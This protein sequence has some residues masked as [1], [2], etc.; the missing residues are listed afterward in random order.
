MPTVALGGKPV[1]TVEEERE[2]DAQRKRAKRENVREVII[3]RC[4]DRRR[5]DYLEKDDINWLR[6]Y[7]GPNSNC[8]DPFWYPF[9]A[10]QLEMIH[11]IRQAIEYGGDQSLAASRGEGKTTIFER[12]LTKYTLQ[13][14]VKFSV[15]CAATGGLAAQS[16][17]SIKDAI[18]NNTN[19]SADYPEVCIPVHALEN[20]PNRAHYQL[21]T[22]VRHDNNKAFTKHPSKF[23]W[24]GQE[25]IL[26]DVPGAPG[27]AGIIAT[28]GLDAAVRGLKRKGMRPQLVG[29]D[30]PDTEDSAR[31]EDQA[32]KL[33]SRIDRS[34]GGLGGQQR[35]VARVMLTTL[36]S[37][38]AV[39]YKFTDP[40]QKPTWKAKRF[41]FLIKPPDRL[42]LWD[43][44]VTLRV[45]GLQA[46]D[47]FAR[48]AHQFYLDNRAVMNAG[49][50][51]ANPNRFN[52]QLLPDG[53]QMEV[54]ALQRYYN[55]VAKIGEDAVEAEYNNN[56]REQTGPVESGISARMIQKKC[57]GYPRKIVPPDCVKL[58][59][60]IDCRKVSLHW[61]VRAWREDGTGFTIDYGVYE[62]QGTTYGSDDG[63]D[64]AL[65]RAILAYLDESKGIY[66]TSG[67]G[68][69]E[70]DRTLIDASWRSE[71]VYGACLAA[72]LGVD[73][74]MGEGESSGCVRRGGALP[75][76]RSLT[77]LPGDN[78]YMTRT[79]RSQ[80]WLIMAKSDFWKA[81]EHDRWMTALNKPGAMTIFGDPHIKPDRLSDDEKHHHAY[82]HHIINEVEIEEPYKGGMRRRWKAKSEN[83][84][85]LDAS[86]YANVAA[87]IEGVRLIGSAPESTKTKMKA[88]MSLADMA[89]KK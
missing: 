8:P 46:D 89:T 43:E 29:I 10:Q 6:F 73:P 14:V 25:I 76:K 78:Y 64:I 52:P 66:T 33:E 7:Y 17:D 41:R 69:C 74:V 56:P 5:R 9:T 23:T 22:G 48:E 65:K 58:T 13:G 38:I 87:R 26:P 34:L 85:W 75:M 18:E 61:V 15:L 36:Q 63:L 55:E 35:N 3:P 12:L 77:K 57:N 37:R 82:A 24:C 84:H 30:D 28:R 40:K 62:V 50:E 45:F 16:L 21:V 42:D 11:A 51:I 4:K 79:D 49:A 27:R 72:G 1:L 54:S 71:A 44:Y 2:R 88:R 59:R 31:S 32:E 47:E 70:I 19:L 67:G 53:S 83:T 60:G 81:W 39:S 68:V 86:Y 80:G 20:T